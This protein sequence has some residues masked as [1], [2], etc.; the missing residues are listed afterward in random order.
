MK[1]TIKYTNCGNIKDKH[2]FF[3]KFIKFLNKKIPLKENLTIEFLGERKGNM[4]T[5]SRLP[6]Y[7][8]ILTV[9][10]MNRDVCRTLAHEWVHEYQLSILK[11][12][13]GPNIGGKNED[14]ANSYA[15][16]LIKMFEKEYPKLEEKMYE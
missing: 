7:L 15:G 16:Q 13:H 2:Q 5:G 12:P 3:E 11:R 9:N 1:V 14:E 10:R 8:K 4:S 6:N